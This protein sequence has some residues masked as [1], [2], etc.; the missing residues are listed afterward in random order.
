MKEHYYFRHETQ[1]S[2]KLIMIHPVNTIQLL[3]PRT[4]LTS[5]YAYICVCYFLYRYSIQVQLPEYGK[6]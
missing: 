2:H 4:N 6:R 3:T 1:I 5:N